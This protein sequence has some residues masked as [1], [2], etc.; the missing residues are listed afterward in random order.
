MRKEWFLDWEIKWELIEIQEVLEKSLSEKVWL[1]K[2]DILLSVNWKDINSSNI[3]LILKENIWKAIE[4]KY[5]RNN[6]ELKG[7][8]VCPEWTCLL[9]ISYIA[10]NNI[11]IK[12][13]K[14]NLWWAMLASLKEV[15]WEFLL[16]M[17]SLGKLWKWLVSFDRTKTKNA[18]NKMSWPIWAAKFWKQVFLHRW[19]F[20]LLAFCWIIS[21]AL[22]I[23]N[24]LP[25]PALDWGRLLWVFIQSWFRIKKEKYFVIENWFNLVSFIL[26][27]WLWIYIILLDIWRIS[28]F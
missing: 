23:F 2:W 14:F 1:K 24:I 5:K 6:E 11:K 17:N 21:L 26:L 9:W 4:I 16:T 15:K 25:I 10:N 18:V 22:A 12:K 19:V 13:I 20:G 8:W 7:N 3:Q 28:R 27:M